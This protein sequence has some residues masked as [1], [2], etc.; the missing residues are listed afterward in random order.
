MK[1]LE[2]YDMRV[3]SLVN[4]L[5]VDE[6]P[7]FSYKIQSEK[8][9]VL[10]KNYHIVV[11][12]NA[13]F[14]NPIW[15]SGVIEGRNS[16]AVKYEGGKLKAATRYY[17]RVN[18]SSNYND[19]AS[20]C[21]YFETGLMG[22][23]ETVWSGAKW[24]SNPGDTINTDGISEY[25]IEA[26]FS[27][28]KKAGFVIGARDKEN[29]TLIE[30]DG[31]KICAY[32]YSDRAWDDGMQTVTLTGSSEITHGFD[33][34]IRI[35]SRNG[36]VTVVL[37]GEIVMENE[38]LIRREEG[39]HPRQLTLMNFGFKADGKMSVRNFKITNPDGNRV[40]ISDNFNDGSYL[41]SLGKI[42]DNTLIAENEFNITT[43]SPALKLWKKFEAKGKI[44]SAKVYSSARGFYDLYVN[45]EKVNTD[46]YNP[47]FTDYRKR[48]YYQTFDI[49]EQIRNGIN[50]VGA[51]VAKG[52]FTGYL[53][54]NPSPMIYGR[55]NSFIAKLVLKYEN[56]DE[57]IVVTDGSWRW[58][59]RGHIINSDYLQGEHWDMRNRFDWNEL[60]KVSSLPCSIEKWTEPVVPTNGKLDNLKFELVSQVGPT[61]KIERIIEAKYAGEQPKGHQIYDLGQNIVGSV[62]IKVKGERGHSIKIRYGEM[63]Y[64]TGR[65]YLANLRTAANT[66]IF[67]LAGDEGGEEFFPTFTSHGYRY[68][69]I[70]GCEAKQI[71]SVEGIAVTNTTEV[72]GGFECSNPLI[73][74]LQ[75]NIQW[76]QRDNSLL[77][78]TD[79][80][81]RN[82][83]M[84][85]TG[86]AQIFAATAAYNM[87][88]KSF[89]NKW[90]IDVRD[91]QIMYNRKG[92]VPDTAPLGGDNR[93]MG[94][95]A[96]W[97]DA[98]VIVPWEM[99]KAYGDLDILRNNYGMM[100]AWV[101]YQSLPERQNCGVRTVNGKE[102]PEKSDL[103]KENYIQIQQS[104]GDH[105]TFDES[106]PFILS[107]TA[108]AA[109]VARILSEVAHILGREDDSNR[110]ADRYRAVKQAFNEAWVCED[111]SIAYWGEQSKREIN[112]IYYS[113][114]G[115]KH[116]SQTAYAL[117]I[118]FDLIPEEKLPNTIKYFKRSIEERDNCLSVGFLGISHLAPA[119]EK[120]GLQDKAFELLEQEKFPSWLYSV[121]NGATTIWER[122]NSYVAESD[123]FGDV[124]MNSFNHYSYGAIGEWMFGAIAGIKPYSAGYEKIIL[125]PKIGKKLTYTKAY[126]N[127]PYG[128]IRS[129]W[130]K[131]DDALYY[132][133][134]VPANTT[135]TIRLLGMDDIEVGSGD[136][137]FCTEIEK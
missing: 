75:S 59:N 125:A 53:A 41:E 20:G 110:Y 10:Q 33:N 5:G 19:T 66:D 90:L 135:A 3:L 102:V 14:S 73:N 99:Y 60:E 105:L 81:Q 71:I 97:G 136:Y 13:D 79:C 30:L 131:R 88:V 12:E 78:F 87:N 25:A 106:T 126:H 101:E 4:P 46:F 38:Q 39:H 108:Y 49:T 27:F 67:T 129:E 23:D 69:E 31:K 127:S 26:D 24:I 92:A 98:A 104:R 56:G 120:A 82:E 132:K 63:C 100:R 18:I 44:A 118:D 113:E 91:A 34:H 76:G 43:A 17:W 130:K 96:G 84:G 115:E 114:Y 36:S 111:G 112:E 68:I 16:I 61:A 21:A 55:K 123:T 65:I 77:V 117:A 8:N 62:R 22:T 70:T 54:Y 58:T 40:Y 128:I 42:V 109:Y 134:T 28:D 133:F 7:I 122:W 72:T 11:S 2:V 47:G 116:P 94:G 35:E 52:Y 29:Y 103:A 119:L 45:G 85:W 51:V 124:S 74:Q 57:E 95:C 15:D 86:D 80:P 50:T 93:P 83:R 37:N 64:G 121:K 137:E 107:A 1:K 89:M 48:I 6:I 9:N 32:E